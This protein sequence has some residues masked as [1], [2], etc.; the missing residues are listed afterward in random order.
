MEQFAQVALPV[1]LAKTF[2]YRIGD[3]QRPII[4]GRVKVPFGRQHKVGIVMGLSSTASVDAS[5]LK[6]I[7]AVLD[8]QPVWTPGVY[9]LLHWASRFYHHPLGDAMGAVMPTQLRK[10][11]PA[12]LQQQKWW[13]ITESG[14]N[15]PLSGLSRA[16]KQARV[17]QLLTHGPA[18]HAD[19]I[20][21]DIGAPVTKNRS[22]KRLDSPLHT[23]ARC[24][25]L[26]T[27]FC[28]DR[29]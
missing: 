5:Q 28:R 15:Q 1:P 12:T 19:L 2:D 20:E 11:R 21:Q 22:R 18:T 13:Q 17:L 3:N 9:N 8:T 29:R 23:T 27:A 14:Q 26:A 24:P 6:A 10:G 7:D 4:G 16:P 25:S